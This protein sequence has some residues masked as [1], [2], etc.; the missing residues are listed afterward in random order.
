MIKV[1]VSGASG[2]MGLMILQKVFANKAIKLVAALDRAGSPRVGE[3][4]G[5]PLG[6]TSGIVV[7]DDVTQ[8]AKSEAQVLIDFTRPEAT[9]EYLKT[10]SECGCA[11]VIGT[12]GFSAQA[13]AEIVAA[14]QK[15]PVI[16]APNMSSAMNVT[17]DLVAAA[18]KLLPDYDCEIV[19]MHHNLKIDAPSGTAIEMGHRVAEARGQKLEDVGVWGRHGRT[20][21]REPGTI[22]FAALRGGDVVGDHTVIFAGPGE[23]IEITHRSS[24]R[25]GYA[26]GAIRAAEFIC[27]KAAGLYSMADVLG[28]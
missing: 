14:T 25:Q 21:K 17:F 9:L 1:A 2:R 18:A 13:K 4:A 7:T 6:V 8:I 20:G 12:T 10:C 11:V 22:G 24:S 3:D 28:L 5:A 16:F 26:N 19:E 27:G 15:I 23:R